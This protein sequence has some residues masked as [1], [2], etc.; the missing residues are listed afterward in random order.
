MAT[1]TNTTSTAR[2]GKTES[3]KPKQARSARGAQAREKL[4]AAA[5]RVLEKVGYHQMR[6]TDVTKEAGV[7]A[8]LFYHYFDDLKS[9][10]LEVL[11]D[12][13][14]RFIDIEEIESG[15]KKDDWY[16]LYLSHF[17]MFVD[18]YAKHPGLMRCLLQL[19]DEIPEFH[20]VHRQSTL[21]QM[22]WLSRALPK[23]FPESGMTQEESLL[24]VSALSGMSESILREYYITRDPALRQCELSNE[25][26]AEFL[27]MMLYRGLFLT[28][29]PA[30]KLRFADKLAK[31]SIANV[32]HRL[33][34]DAVV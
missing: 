20:E 23:I 5:M 13:L 3:T 12:F 9:L 31:V 2:R 4:K 32:V 1:K 26:M 27:A 30:E 7:A 34:Q 21:R 10:T 6:V 29:P 8:G 15:V 14:E 18:I 28:N 22:H 25:E 33:P 16:R 11:T 17:E 19:S 24:M